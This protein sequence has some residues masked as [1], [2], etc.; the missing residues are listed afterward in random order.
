MGDG[1][2]TDEPQ[3]LLERLDDVIAQVRRQGRA[4]VAAQAAAE[5]CLDAVEAL[6]ATVEATAAYEDDEDNAGDDHDAP[7]PAPWLDAL[8][9]VA[10]AVDRLT[11]TAAAM[12]CQRKQTRGFWP[13]SRAR[14]S[15]A[16]L[17]ALAGGLRVL[18]AQL[19]AAF[20]TLDVSCIDPQDARFDAEQH[21]AVERRAGL[22]GR[23]LE[24]VRPGYRRGARLVREAE[25]VV[26]SGKVA[27]EQ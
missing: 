11:V 3:Q 10:D 2:L 12:A 26:G 14:Q 15:D 27:K 9:P 7:K 13:F 21:R 4:S 16:E 20:Q 22:E 18:Q 24:V 6:Q 25:V 17:E 8:L 23:V 19:R 5:S 1:P